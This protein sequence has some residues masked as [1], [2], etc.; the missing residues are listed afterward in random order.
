MTSGLLEYPMFRRMHVTLVL[1]GSALLAAG[2]RS[3]TG[4]EGRVAAA[5]G[6]EVTLHV[7]DMTERQKLT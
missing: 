2:C 5:T 7:P 6:A 1:A 3:G 4:T